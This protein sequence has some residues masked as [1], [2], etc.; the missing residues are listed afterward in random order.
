MSDGEARPRVKGLP[1]LLRPRALWAH[2]AD[3][4]L[5]V[6][7]LLLRYI[8]PFAAI[9]PIA[10]AIGGE[11]LGIEVHGAFF[12]PPIVVDHLKRGTSRA[13]SFS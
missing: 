3:A 10:A 9:G 6:R 1:L 4:E 8:L 2:V 11:V 7:D 12:H 5:S 13:P